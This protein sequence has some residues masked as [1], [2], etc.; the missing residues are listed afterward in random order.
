VLET[1]MGL[2][3][4]F[5]FAETFVVPAVAGSYRLINGGHGTAR[6]VKAFL[7]KPSKPNTP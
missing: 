5:S 4:T 1:A 6:V 7:K 3:H 2:R